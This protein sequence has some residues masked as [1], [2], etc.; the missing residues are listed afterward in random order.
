MKNTNTKRDL[1]PD[2]EKIVQLHKTNS[3]IL[4]FSTKEKGG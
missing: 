2:I 4:V 1:E 3:F